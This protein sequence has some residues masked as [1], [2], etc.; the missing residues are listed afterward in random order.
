MTPSSLDPTALRTRT[1]LAAGVVLGGLLILL[2]LTTRLI[3]LPNYEA[4]ER[5]EIQDEAERARDALDD[6][7]QDLSSQLS[8]WAAW[9]ETYAFAQGRDP[10][11]PGRN[12]AQ[13]T[14]VD[15]RLS[16]FAILNSSRR[17]LYG[18]SFRPAAGMGALPEAF[19]DELGGDS[20]LVE[21]ASPS[22]SVEGILLLREGP[23]LIAAR[24]IS[25]NEQMGPIEGTILWGR[26]LDE[27][28]VAR[29]ARVT[30]LSLTVHPADSRIG[31]EEAVLTDLF[32]AGRRVAFEV[33][34]DDA[35]AGYARVDDVY[36]LP[37]IVLRVESDRAIVEQGLRTILYFL[38]WFGGL[39]LALGSVSVYT[40]SNLVLSRY[41]TRAMEER[42]LSDALTGVGNRR[43][44]VDILDREIAKVERYGGDLAVILLDLDRFKEVNDRYGHSAGDRILVE[45]SRL[46][47]DHLRRS[48]LLGRWG[49]EEFVVLAPET[50]LPG[51]RLLAERL[52]MRLAV[53]RFEG[54]GEVTASFGVAG[55]LPG[56]TGEMILHRADQGLYE[57]KAAG[58]NAVR[59][60]DEAA[61]LPPAGVSSPH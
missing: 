38:A 41:A 50:D 36:G 48:D 40:Y 59:T 31:P 52:R 9:N 55:H 33:L 13:Q 8:D 25:T 32:P 3:V 22:S 15:L 4:M 11:Y 23:V 47:A 34:R 27:T 19:L 14:F 37:A 20:I 21:H 45:A 60:S 53:H 56:D 5:A 24:P 57:A 46:I 58:R 54:V 17:V 10:A 29:I 28:E 44:I 12:I 16:L 1:F 61:P 39:G 2:F 7:I 18:E 35:I 30:H 51:A 49:G 6:D 26:Q 43:L 42:A